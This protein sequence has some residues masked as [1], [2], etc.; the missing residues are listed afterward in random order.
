[1]FS[2]VTKVKNISKIEK[3]RDRNGKVIERG[4][5]RTDGKA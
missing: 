3:E 1:M 4:T 5:G 2:T